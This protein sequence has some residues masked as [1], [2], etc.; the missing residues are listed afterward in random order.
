[1]FNLGY[2]PSSDNT[3]VTHA[4]T[5]VEAVRAG[6]ESLRPG[7]ALRIIAYTGYPG[8][9]EEA[10]AV[11]LLLRELPAHESRQEIIVGDASAES[12]PR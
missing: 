12:S 1:M 6:I 9:R 8:G 10:Q 4:G 11:E 3:G 5:T 7:G 2:L